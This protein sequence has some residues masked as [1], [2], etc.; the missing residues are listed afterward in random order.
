MV[1][2]G[3][4]ERNLTVAVIGAGMIGGAIAKSLLEQGYG[5][6]VVATRRSL[7]K[8][9]YLEELGASILKDNRRA[10]AQSDLVILCVKPRDVRGVLEEMS[11]EVEGK[12]VISTAAAVPLRFYKDLVPKARFV[13]TMPNVDV[14][15]RE[16]FTAYCCDEDV[17]PEDRKKV[18]RIFDIMGKNEEVEERHMDAITALSGSGPAYIALIV[19]AMMYAG[20]KVGLPRDLALYASA[21][22]VL[23]TGKLMLET[24]KSS[25]EVKEMVLTP[26]GTTIDGIYELENGGVRTA[27]MRAV[28]SATKKSEKIVAN[29]MQNNP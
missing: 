4:G 23:G 21:Q 8:I 5:D 6:R 16:A 24:K 27:I 13:R 25:S 1:E 14:L 15:V 10:A 11:Q 20:L 7:E 9:R 17:T 28:E 29:L 12:L 22:T 2:D 3:K 26:A 18:K 19:E